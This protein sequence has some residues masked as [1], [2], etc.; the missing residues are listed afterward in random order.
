MIG[1]SPAEPP[2]T[3]DVEDLIRVDEVG[4]AVSIDEVEAGTQ[5]VLFLH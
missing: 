4:E 2:P 3:V 1:L 5:P